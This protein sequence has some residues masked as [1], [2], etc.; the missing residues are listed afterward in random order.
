MDMIKNRLEKNYKKLKNWAERAQI[1]A[2]RLYDRDIPEYPYIVDIYK[3]HFL[4]YDKSD[5][6]DLEKN[7]LP[8]VQE[9]LKALFKCDDSKIVIKKRERQEGLKQY[10]KLDAKEETFV[11]RESQALLKVNLYDYLDTGLF[12]DHRPMRQKVFKSVKD[13][14]FL[15]LFCYTGSVSVF[16]ALGGAT[17]TSVDMSQTYLR[18]A[19]ENFQLNNLD[20][21]KHNFINADVLEWLRNTKSPNTFDVIFLD[22]P[23][24]S[25]SKKMDDTFEVERDQEFLVES[26]MNMLRPEGILYFSNNKRKFKISPAVLSKYKVKEITAES[27]P[28]DF[29]DKKIHNC[30]EIR[31]N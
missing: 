29:H 8:H 10:E 19:Q 18:W 3:D 28:Q 4:I 21:A 1:E 2:Y 22:P 11:V 20:P 25:N 27:I 12:L 17:T 16:A 30:F 7:H 23:T 31:S 13:K 24:F 5:L 15:N 14:K 6:R 9:A 26:C